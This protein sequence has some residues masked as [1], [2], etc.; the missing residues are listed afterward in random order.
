MGRINRIGGE[1]VYP[2]ARIDGKYLTDGWTKK[3]FDPDNPS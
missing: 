3:G 2:G 1:P